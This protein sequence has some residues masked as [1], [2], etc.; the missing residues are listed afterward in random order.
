ME[1]QK[2]KKSDLVTNFSDDDLIY[3][4]NPPVVDAHK[5]GKEVPPIIKP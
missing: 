2:K 4:D 5:I 1:N 3:N